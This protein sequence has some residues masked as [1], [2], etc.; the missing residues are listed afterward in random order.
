MPLTLAN[1]RAFLSWAI[2]LLCGAIFVRTFLIDGPLRVVSGSMA[3]A[4]E[5]PRVALECHECGFPFTVDANDL[6]SDGLAICPNCGCRTNDLS[7]GRFQLGDVVYADKLAYQFR[8]PQRWETV[9]VREP[10][11]ER[12]WAVKRIVG[13]PGET[14]EIKDGDVFANGSIVGKNWRYS[15]WSASQVY[16]D[17]HRP[18]TPSK[19][20]SHWE[21]RDS[22]SGVWGIDDN[23]YVYLPTELNISDQATRLGGF[24]WLRYR[25]GDGRQVTDANA[26]SQNVPGDSKEVGDVWIY[27]T[28]ELDARSTVALVLNLPDR[29][30]EIW[31]KAGSPDVV[32]YQN[33]NYGHPTR[34]RLDRPLQPATSQSFFFG[35][36]DG[37]L[38]FGQGN[39]RIVEIPL[40]PQRSSGNVSLAPVEIGAKNGYARVEDLRVWRDIYYRHPHGIDAPWS[41]GRPL[42]ED[43]YLLLGDHSLISLDSRQWGR[44]VKSSEIVGRAVRW[45]GSD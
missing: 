22:T 17:R 3:P 28:L 4:I 26:E 10:G 24:D 19:V 40:T 30:L 31:L 43:E 34:V 27:P 12:I 16:S 41:L 36:L 21:A 11:N 35:C 1:L 37:N 15:W 23:L 44:G 38:C 2:L 25:H 7:K 33:F 6:P 8:A 9:I 29:R 45:G 32:V 42:G 5:G 14:I 39:G 13:L 20:A 18:R